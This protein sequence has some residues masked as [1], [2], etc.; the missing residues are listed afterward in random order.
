[1]RDL[2][3]GTPR[4]GWRGDVAAV[5]SGSVDNVMHPADVPQG[6][7]ILPNKE[8]RHFVGANNSRIEH[9]GSCVTTTAGA[10]GAE[11]QTGWS[12]AEVSRPLH[13][14]GKLCGPEDEPRQD[15]L[16]NSKKCVVVPPGVV[17][18]ILQ[19]VQ[20]LM[21][22]DRKGGLYVTEMELQGFQR[23]GASA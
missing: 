18:R 4:G 20:P 5:D 2:R 9:Y 10:N 14:V 7:K 3:G 1:M 15:V 6:T 21:Q 8:D 23:P 17:D 11:V 16:F 13:S 19:H 12:L 22:Y